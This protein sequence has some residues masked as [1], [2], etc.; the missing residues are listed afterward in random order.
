MPLVTVLLTSLEQLIGIPPG[1][2]VVQQA[3]LEAVV[4]RLL[5]R[6]K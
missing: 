5:D 6:P 3:H 2:L 4:S 1:G